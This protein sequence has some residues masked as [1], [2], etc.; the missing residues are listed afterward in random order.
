MKEQTPSQDRVLK[1]LA[2][3]ILDKD[4][5]DNEAIVILSLLW[6]KDYNIWTWIH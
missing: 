6:N 2:W 4:R 3:K 1:I 5:K